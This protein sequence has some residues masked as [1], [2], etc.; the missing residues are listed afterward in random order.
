[1][2]GLQ[3]GFGAERRGIAGICARTQN[4]RLLSSQEDTTQTPGGCTAA[5]LGRSMRLSGGEDCVL[6]LRWT[7]LSV[8]GLMLPARLLRLATR[9]KQTDG[10]G[11][12]RPK[13]EGQQQESQPS[14]H[15]DTRSSST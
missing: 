9:L 10:G 1:M 14:A 7:L 8:R 4:S 5:N 6:V 15:E 11:A 13:L 3:K 12:H 2:D